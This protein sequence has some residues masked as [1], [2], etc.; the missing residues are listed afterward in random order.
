MASAW[1]FTLSIGINNQKR[2]VFKMSKLKSSP[3][4]D[5]ALKQL[6]SILGRKDVNI[7]YSD[8]AATASTDGETINLPS[9]C[10]NSP[11]AIQAVQGYID[12]ETGHIRWSSFSLAGKFQSK[13]PAWGNLFN[14]LEDVRIERLAIKAYPGMFFNLDNLTEYMKDNGL[15]QKP[16]GMAQLTN[17]RAPRAAKIMSTIEAYILYHLGHKILRYRLQEHAEVSRKVAVKLVGEK[18]VSDI[19]AFAEK[20]Q[21]AKSTQD[22][23]DI[24]TKIMEYLKQECNNPQEQQ[25][26]Q[27]SGSDNNQSSSAADVLSLHHTKN[28]ASSCQDN[29]QQSESNDSQDNQQQSE[30]NDSQDNQQQSDQDTGTGKGTGG[31]DSQ[32][33]QLQPDSQNSGDNQSSSDDNQ[34]NADSGL[35]FDNIEEQNIKVKSRGDALADHLEEK[36]KKV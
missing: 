28:R 33:D 30:S 34:S 23:A 7:H 3:Y 12:H 11:E 5:K 24:T 17:T 21:H 31:Q 29:Q 35:D 10:M 27:Q 13:G 36:S 22:A 25:Q 9:E 26:P 4:S 1:T 18:I 19:T 16:A 6:A 8:S 32:D 2:G 14:I 15:Y 20:I